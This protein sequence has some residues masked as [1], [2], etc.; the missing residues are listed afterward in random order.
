[1]SSNIEATKNT[2]VKM[3]KTP[4]VGSI[5]INENT[6]TTNTTAITLKL[7]ANDSISG[8][9]QMHF[10]NDNSTW[11]T[12][13]TYAP[14]KSWVLEGGDGTKTVYVQFMDY[15]GLISQTYPYPKC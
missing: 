5:T 15:A 1:L 2:T 7:S 14:S 10:S 4:P 8:V 3:D 9:D 11:S 6:T 13:E 12:W